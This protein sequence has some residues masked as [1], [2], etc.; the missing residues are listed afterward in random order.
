MSGNLTL[1]LA[2]NDVLS[3]SDFAA[4][5]TLPINSVLPFIDY[6]GTWNGGTFAGLLENGIVTAGANQFR[7]RYDGLD[8]GS[9]AVTLTAIAVPEPDGLS[10]I[11]LG[12]LL[13]VGLR[14][15]KAHKPSR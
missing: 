6:T 4:S 7:I 8:N 9:N 3:T 11:T 5:T 1:D 13:L 10:L 2:K 14:R 12:T 15:R